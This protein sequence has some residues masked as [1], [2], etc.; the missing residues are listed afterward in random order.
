[1]HGGDPV[2]RDREDATASRAD[3]AYVESPSVVVPQHVAVIERG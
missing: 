3:A 2:T 1:V